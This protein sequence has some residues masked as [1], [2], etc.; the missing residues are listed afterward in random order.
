MKKNYYSKRELNNLGT[1]TY[2]QRRMRRS[3]IDYVSYRLI[4]NT[5]WISDL[6]M[7]WFFKIT[8]QDKSFLIIY[9]QKIRF[10]GLSYQHNYRLR[11]AICWILDKSLKKENFEK[12]IICDL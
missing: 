8:D 7:T 4:D 10:E 1:E 5:M 9:S 6:L 3:Y 11:L 12:N 2:N